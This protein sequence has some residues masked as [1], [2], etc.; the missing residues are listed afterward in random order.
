MSIQVTEIYVSVDVEADGQVPG[1]WSMT[2]LG[3]VVAGY[4]TKD[5]QVVSIDVTAPENRFYGELK[6]ISE[7]W[8]SGAMVV[9]I[10]E[11]F[12]AEAAKN[13]PT[14]KLR[15][16]YI[17]TYGKNPVTVMTDFA[18]W[19]DER[20]SFYNAKGAVFAGYPLGFD[21]MWTYWYLTTYSEVGSPFGFSRHIDIKTLFAIKSGELIIHST[22][23]NI[24]KRFMSNLPHTHRADQDAAEQ[25]ELL[26][27][28]L[29]W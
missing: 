27:N 21:W 19:V 6:P 26:M 16:A 9:G 3:A 5:G 4:K 11:G 10:F 14:G 2:A 17:E 7:E 25:G 18:N 20:T 24:P 12:D 28:L 23:R 8:E 29:K 13:D 15:R 22:K 1:R